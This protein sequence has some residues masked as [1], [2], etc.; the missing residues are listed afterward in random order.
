MASKPAA[1]PMPGMPSSG[2]PPAAPKVIPTA[3][4]PAPAPG[5]LDLDHMD[6]FKVDAG[7]PPKPAAPPVGA[8]K[9]MA[10]PMPGAP[11][12][13]A[14][15]PPPGVPPGGLNASKPIEKN[16]AKEGDGELIE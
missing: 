4:K 8:P 6:S 13:P 1:P 9:P 14:P 3:M 10:P 7:A 5:V 16:I 11:P 2:A 15:L 12:R